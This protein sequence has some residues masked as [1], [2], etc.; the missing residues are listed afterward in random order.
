MD[1]GVHREFQGLCIL[2]YFYYTLYLNHS[3][4]F[5]HDVFLLNKMENLSRR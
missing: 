1:L 3:T 5:R 2:F 4:G